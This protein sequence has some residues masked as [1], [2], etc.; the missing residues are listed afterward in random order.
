MAKNKLNVVIDP[1]EPSLA[2]HLSDHPAFQWIAKNATN[3]LA[4]VAL[5]FAILFFIYRMSANDQT[6]AEND[7]LNAS[8]DFNTF[9]SADAEITALQHEEA[10]EQL[11]TILANR[12]DLH[13]KYDAMIAQALL[14]K[15]RANEAIPYAERTFKRIAKDN[16]PLHENFAKIT[17]LIGQAEYSQALALSQKLKEELNKTTKDNNITTLS[18][19]NLLRLAMLENALDNKEEELKAWEELNATLYT[20]EAMLSSTANEQRTLFENLF[21]NGTISLKN[22]IDHRQKTLKNELDRS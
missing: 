21:S 13:E 18:T 4:A 11:N 19:Y 2:D 5:I 6:K 8:K 1:K 16:L 9:I 12:P 20:P 14:T 10:F 3:I 7:Y 17:I 22:Y 15:E